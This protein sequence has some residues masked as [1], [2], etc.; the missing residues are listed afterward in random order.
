MMKDDEE[1]SGNILKLGIRLSPQRHTE[2]AVEGPRE[3]CISKT[4]RDLKRERR[5]GDSG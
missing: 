1:G 5:E 2:L 4:E 3:A